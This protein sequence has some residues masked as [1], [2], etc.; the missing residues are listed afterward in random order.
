ME[1][2][3]SRISCRYRRHTLNA[4]KFSHTLLLLFC[5]LEEKCKR[6][7]KLAVSHKMIIS[8]VP[9]I[10]PRP[11]RWKRRILATRPH[12]ITTSHE[13]KLVLFTGDFALVRTSLHV[14]YITEFLVLRRCLLLSFV[15]SLDNI[16]AV[17]YGFTAVYC[18]MAHIKQYF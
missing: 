3:Y 1:R 12:G 13:D 11:R 16:F 6:K 4:S 9:G 15:P 2:K 14:Q 7:L 8:P 5:L 17:W 10:E 18:T